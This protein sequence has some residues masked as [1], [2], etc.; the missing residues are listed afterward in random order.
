VGHAHAIATVNLARGHQIRQR[1]HCKRVFVLEPPETLRR[2]LFCGEPRTTDAA[3]SR[4]TVWT[5]IAL[6][7]TPGI[8]QYIH[9][10]VAL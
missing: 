6:H 4:D 8:P 5:S 9:P 10:V 3:C 7:T 2:R 1:L